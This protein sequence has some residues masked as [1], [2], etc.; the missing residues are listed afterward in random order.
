MTSSSTHQSSAF[1]ESCTL[2]TRRE[3]S[4][5]AMRESFSTTPE[6][7]V[8]AVLGQPQPG[9]PVLVATGEGDERTGSSER[10]PSTA[11][12]TASASAPWQTAPGV[13]PAWRLPAQGRCAATR[14]GPPGTV[15]KRCSS[16]SPYVVRASVVRSAS[17]VLPPLRTD[18]QPATARRRPSAGA[19][20]VP[21][22]S[23]APGFRVQARRR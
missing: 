3:A 2:S 22:T 14:T 9:V 17:Y 1:V 10:G 7:Q 21:T 11:Q 8:E 18:C 23:Q 19:G 6:P 15:G 16:F 20:F 5:L 13:H 4:I 12:P